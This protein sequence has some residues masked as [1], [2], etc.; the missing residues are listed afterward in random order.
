MKVNFRYSLSDRGATYVFLSLVPKRI[1][2]CFFQIRNE[3]ECKPIHARGQQILLHICINNR[4][5]P[6]QCTDAFK[7]VI[8]IPRN[9]CKVMNLSKG[10]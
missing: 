3:Q 2:Y 1:C 10:S 5:Y 9:R 7:A 4:Y 6:C 8:H